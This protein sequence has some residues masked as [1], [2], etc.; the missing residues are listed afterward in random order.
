[1][2][3]P[4]LSTRG[5]DCAGR[6]KKVFLRFKQDFGYLKQKNPTNFLRYFESSIASRRAYFYTKKLTN[7]TRFFGQHVCNFLKLAYNYKRKQPPVDKFSLASDRWRCLLL[8]PLKIIYGG[9]FFPFF[10]RENGDKHAMRKE[11]VGDVV[12]ATSK[13]KGKLLMLPPFFCPFFYFLV[14]FFSFLTDGEETEVGTCVYL[15]FLFPP[16]PCSKL[17]GGGQSCRR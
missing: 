4:A 9:F 3:V 8:S 12:L 13:G 5:R 14:C 11:R 1:M 10:A 2:S 6:E 7:I 17:G 16:P 15:L